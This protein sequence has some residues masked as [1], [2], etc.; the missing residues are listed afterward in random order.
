MGL[1]PVTAQAQPRI[2]DYRFGDT[3]LATVNLVED[4]AQDV[5]HKLRSMPC[6]VPASD[7]EL[8]SHFFRTAGGAYLR[9]DINSTG[10]ESMT[11]SQEPTA[12]DV[13]YAPLNQTIPIRTGKGIQLGDSMERVSRVYGEPVQTFQ[14]G[15][16]VKFRYESELDRS[17]EWDLIF[18]NGGLVEWTAYA[19]D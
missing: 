11:A 13:C 9:F 4:G 3:Q 12:M 17:Y 10:I 5:E 1:L 14:V 7:R 6:V 15:S 16:L 8:I 2:E 18:R 19:R